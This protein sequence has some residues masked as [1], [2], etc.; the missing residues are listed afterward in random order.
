MDEAGTARPRRR[1]F[2]P[3]L[4]ATVACFVLYIVASA[5][6][7][8]ECEPAVAGWTT[9]L[10]VTFIAVPL[11][12][13]MT[14]IAMARRGGIVRRVLIGGVVALVLL[15]PLYVVGATVEALE[16]PNLEEQC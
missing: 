2:V 12:T 11:L 6:G 5:A 13:W 16:C 4:I 7:P 1:L 3:L 15:L 8:C 10:L 9:V 14:I